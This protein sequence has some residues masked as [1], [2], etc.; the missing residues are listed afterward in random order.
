MRN[1]GWLAVLVVAAIL[2]GCGT[3]RAGRQ[4]AAADV[5][6]A[7][8]GTP[9][10]RAAADAA[11]MVA[12][13]VPPPRA[14]RAGRSPVSLLAHAPSE[15]L[16]SDVAV[17]TAWWQVAGRPLT[18]FAWI[19][20]HVPAGFSDVGEGGVGVVPPGSHG[21]PP[22]KP[23]FPSPPLWY[24]DFALP[25]VAGVLVDRTLIVAVAADGR[26]RTAIGVYAEV[27]WVPPKPAA[28]HIPGGARV[29]TIT[30]I[31][32]QLPPAAADHQVTIADPA[33][34]ARIAATVNALPMQ[35]NVGWMECGPTQGPGMQLT[36]RATA[37]GPALA[38]VSAHQELCPL[39]S[40]V[41]GGKMMPV[42]DGAESLFQRVM[43]IGGFHWTDFP[44]PGPATPT[45]TAS[46][47]AS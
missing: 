23:P 10:Q 16:G 39:V 20:A 42:L 43:A 4:P 35:P 9:Q 30:P 11:S 18:V 19:Q 2:A 27:M 38:V 3:V 44:A 46:G 41:I 47:G 17:R 8:H 5:V 33:Q 45:A 37:T 1:A 15:P 24:V 40:V 26:D 34:L 12:G 22:P 36:F 7:A 21:P 29:V 28:E 25:D 14:M 6:I 31:P 32:G 13:F